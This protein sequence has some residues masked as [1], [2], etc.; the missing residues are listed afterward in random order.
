GV[1]ALNT[2]KATYAPGETAQ[3]SM[4]VLDDEAKMVC[5]AVLTLE[6]TTPNKSVDT[7][8][9]GDGTIS[10]N[11]PECLSKEV[12]EKPDYESQ[13]KLDQKGSYIFKLSAITPNGGHT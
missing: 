10:A 6:I 11:L 12:V 5:N 2:D 4:G 13:Y 8:S 1:L 7:L 3:I 9:I